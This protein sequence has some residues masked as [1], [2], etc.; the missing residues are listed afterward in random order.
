MHKAQ[1]TCNAVS[2]WYYCGMTNLKT[3]SKPGGK[4][5]VIGATGSYLDGRIAYDIV[6]AAVLLRF[7][8]R[9]EQEKRCE[10]AKKAKIKAIS[11]AVMPWDE[12]E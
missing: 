4:N 8:K 7:H 1:K 12:R 2:A 3:I 9:Q 11:L 6:E 10:A 5:P